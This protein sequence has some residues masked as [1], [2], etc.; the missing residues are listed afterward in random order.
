MGLH[1]TKKFC[2]AKETINK[3]K[4]PPTQW[5]K[6]FAKDISNK[7]LISKLYKEL[8]QF[9]IKNPNNCILKLA[10]DINRPSSKE[11]I[12]MVNRHM[13]RRST[14]LIIRKVQI[15]TTIRYYLR[16]AIIK[17]HHQMLVR[18]WRK[19]NPCSLLVGM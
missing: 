5:E 2:T 8:M 7:G 6:I 18:M 17:N 1:Q 11:D 15:K 9:N 19:G 12:Q 3:M 14:S 16:M 13:Q 4:R 10:E